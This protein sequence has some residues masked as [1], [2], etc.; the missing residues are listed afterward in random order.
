MAQLIPVLTQHRTD[1][2]VDV[3]LTLDTEAVRLNYDRLG[4]EAP[5]GFITIGHLLPVHTAT[6]YQRYRPDTYL[7]HYV[8]ARLAQPVAYW[9]T[10]EAESPVWA[11]LVSALP[12]EP[13]PRYEADSA[14]GE[15]PLYPHGVAADE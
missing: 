13:Q 15:R 12:V 14:V 2:M 9:A 6:G 7:A 3:M 1:G 5:E 10:V 4:S 11:A 8:A